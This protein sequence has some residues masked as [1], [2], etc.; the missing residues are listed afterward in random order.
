MKNPDWYLNNK[1]DPIK[2]VLEVYD[3]ILEKYLS[4]KD[5]K[6]FIVT[7]LSQQPSS[8]PIYYWRLDS[9]REFL[10]LLKIPFNKVYP[11]MTRDFLI[12]FS[13]EKDLHNAHKILSELTD[14]FQNKLFDV[15]DLK[16]KRKKHICNTYIQSFTRGKIYQ[17]RF[18]KITFTKFI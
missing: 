1:F 12:N 11:R 14:Q 9:H 18:T 17:N 2:D 8:K 10:K 4:L 13:S 5:H 15:L 7:G 16:R 3:D 6:I